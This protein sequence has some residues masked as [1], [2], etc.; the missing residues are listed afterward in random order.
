MTKYSIQQASNAGEE[1]PQS[2]LGVSD[3][4]W[5]TFAKIGSASFSMLYPIA[6][7]TVLK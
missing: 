7:R 5:W 4:L 6:R 3:A 1:A 2:I